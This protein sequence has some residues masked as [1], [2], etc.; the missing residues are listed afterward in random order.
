M[1]DYLPL[2]ATTDS[3]DDMTLGPAGQTGFAPVSVVFTIANKAVDCQFALGDYPRVYWEDFDRVLTPQ[4]GARVSGVYGVRFKSH[5]PGEPALVTAELLYPD[6]PT[7]IGSTEMLAGLTPDGEILPPAAAVEVRDDGVTVVAE[8]SVLDFLDTPDVQIVVTEPNPGEADIEA[9]TPGLNAEISQL[10]IDIAGLIIAQASPNSGVVAQVPGTVFECPAGSPVQFPVDQFP[11]FEIPDAQNLL[12]QG[13]RLIVRMQ[14]V[15]TPSVAPLGVSFGGAF[16]TDVANGGSIPTVIADTPSDTGWFDSG[17]VAASDPLIN[18]P[19]GH[20]TSGGTV[21][22]TQALFAWQWTDAAP[23]TIPVP[24]P[25]I[26]SQ[27]SPAETVLKADGTG[28]A[29]WDWLQVVRDDN[30]DPVLDALGVQ[31]LAMF[32]ASPGAGQSA[33]IP[34]PAGGATVDTECRDA[35]IALLD[36]LRA[37]GDVAP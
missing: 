2:T 17:A 30:G 20:G 6:D 3:Y 8:A 11:P 13:R 36:Y 15:S 26:F 35:L 1:G 24:A 28:G 21:W 32:G 16:E 23:S 25:Q 9:F 34:D 14:W 12:A 7:I 31:N 19:F 18:T 10:Q 22:I 37:R 4:V 27:L 5:T 29:F 33:A